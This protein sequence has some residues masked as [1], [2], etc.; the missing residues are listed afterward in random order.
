M[1]SSICYSLLILLTFT[2]AS[3]FLAKT[4]DKPTFQVTI[5][6]IENRNIIEE[7]IASTEFALMTIETDE[8]D[9]EVKEFE[10]V[11]ARG[12]NPVEHTVV[13]TGNSF[14]LREFADS[15][16]SGDRIVVDIKE[17]AGTQRANVLSADNVIVI[18]IR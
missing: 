1:K 14:D 2:L 3:S 15:A 12:S 5:Q 11:L 7:G 18:H 16:K 13:E 9:T 4:H 6:G 17:I 8:K 10:V